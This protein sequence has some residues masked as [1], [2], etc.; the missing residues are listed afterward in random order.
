MSKP[1]TFNLQLFADSGINF[2][3]FLKKYAGEDG[4]IPADSISK[5][6]SALSSAVGR[7]FVD[8]TRYNAK[9][10]EIET[11]KTDKQTAEDK[12]AAA[13]KWQEKYTKEHE[14]FEKFKA[15]T[16]AKT[17]QDAIKAAYKRDVL[18]AAGIADKYIDTVM[19]ATRFDGMTLDKDGKLD[20]VDELKAAAE[21]KW[22]AFKVKTTTKGANVE[23][24]PANNAPAKKTKDEILAM[25]DVGERQKAIAEN[26]ELFGF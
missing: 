20:K 15:D 13:E 18:K 8:K 10:D 22:E 5:A 26:H 6:A 11:L 12:L 21:T 25:K 3:D 19:E 7:A 23:T 16:E 24:P 9:L 2:E 14:T 1:F 4:N 17:Q